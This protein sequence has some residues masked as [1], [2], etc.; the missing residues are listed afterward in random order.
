[1][2]RPI[3]TAS[4]TT[5][6]LCVVPRRGL[7]AIFHRRSFPCHVSALDCSP[8]GSRCRLSSHTLSWVPSASDRAGFV[9]VALGGVSSWEPNQRQ[10]GAD[11]QKEL[12]KKIS[13]S[14]CL[15]NASKSSPAASSPRGGFRIA[16]ERPNASPTSTFRARRRL[17]MKRSWPCSTSYDPAS[18]L[19]RIQLC[20]PD[21]PVGPQIN[22]AW[23]VEAGLRAPRAQDG[24]I[25]RCRASE[26]FPGT[27]AG[28]LVCGLNRSSPAIYSSSDGLGNHQPG[29]I[30]CGF[31]IVRQPA[32]GRARD[33]ARCPAVARSNQGRVG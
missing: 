12:G 2:T 29:S 20:T 24:S 21:W 7:R 8:S 33:R 3:A 1:M 11:G 5:D 30:T 28:G 15:A 25:R 19:D 17:P 10:D 31:A 4:A 22:R 32:S 6:L 27:A 23:C 9:R 26:R 14:L 18:E 13:L 16:L